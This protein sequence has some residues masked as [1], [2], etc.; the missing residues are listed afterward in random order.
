MEMVSVII[1]AYNRAH[2][3]TRAVESVLRQT[4]DDIEIIVVDDGSQDDTE[5]VVKSMTDSR[6]IYKKLESNHGAA[7]ARNAGVECANGRVI[8]FQDSDDAWRPQKLEKQMAYWKEHPEFA[9]I[10][11]PFEICD[12]NSRNRFPQ[13]GVDM[14]E[15]DIFRALIVRNTIG[16]PTMLM[17]RDSFQETGGFD[18]TLKSLEDWDFAIRFS[19]KNLIGYLDEVM[20]KAYYDREEGLSNHV[21]AYFEGRLR[22]I[23]L[24]REQLTEGGNFDRALLEVFQ[25]AQQYGV[26]EQVQQAFLALLKAMG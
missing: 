8:A 20:V 21:G 9:M 2:L 11:C 6:I 15:G 22:M 26:L 23:A 4:Y 5:T 3:I 13:E 18:V 10:Y 16:T 1:P 25:R 7:Y 17:T 19:R 24:Y 14:L 12:G